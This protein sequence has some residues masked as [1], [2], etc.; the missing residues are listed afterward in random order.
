MAVIACHNLISAMNTWVI[1]KEVLT[2]HYAG[3]CIQN[4][5]HTWKPEVQLSYLTS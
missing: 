2:E 1:V 3:K 5:A 4:I